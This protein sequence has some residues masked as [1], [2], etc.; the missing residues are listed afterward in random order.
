MKQ[1]GGRLLGMG[2]G[3]GGTLGGHFLLADRFAGRQDQ[4]VAG[5]DRISLETR[6]RGLRGR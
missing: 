5:A 4:W 6:S 1:A 3:N 2:G